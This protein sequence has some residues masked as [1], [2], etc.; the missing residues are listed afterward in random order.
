MLFYNQSEKSENEHL[1]FILEAA[2]IG[3]WDLD[4]INGQVVWDERCRQ[5]F[6]FTAGENVTY[7]EVLR[8]MHPDDAKIVDV[9]VKRALNPAIDE[10]YE[11][12][13]RVVGNDGAVRWILSK[14]KAYF[15]N[16]IAV[17]FAG[18][19]QDITEAMSDRENAVISARIAE[20]ALRG[21]N[22]GYFRVLLDTDEMEYSPDCARILT[23]NESTLPTHDALKK[24]IHPEDRPIRTAA[25]ELSRRTGKLDYEARVIWEDGSVHWMRAT[26]TYFRGEKGQ[27]D[28][29]AGTVHDTSSAVERELALAESE[30]RFR[31]LIEEAPVATCLFVGKEMR[32]E[33][34]NEIMLGYWGK[35]RSVMGKPFAVGVP[36]MIGQPFLDILDKVYTT[37]I[38][39]TDSGARADLEVDGVLGTY[40]FDFTYK[41]LRNADGEVY[42][43]MDMAVDVTQQV[44]ARQKIEEAEA[45]LRGAIELAELGTWQLDLHTFRMEFSDRMKEWFGYSDDE[46]ITVEKTLLVIRGDEKGLV[47]EKLRLARETGSYD[48]E[49][50]IIVGGKERILHAQG[51]TFYDAHQQPYKI[52]GTAQDVTAQRMLQLSLEEEVQ[53]R[54]EELLAVNEELS[55][56]NEELNESNK[57]LVH[58]NEELA[59]YAYVA[60]HDLQEPLRKIRMFSGI[61]ENQKE[62]PVENRPI[63]A[64]IAQSAERMSLLIRDLLDFSRL[65]K[66]E[67]HL[68]PVDLSSVLNAVISDFELMIEEKQANVRIGRLPV[69]WGVALQ[70]NQLFYNLLSNA[71]K[72]TRP[73]VSPEIVIDAEIIDRDS[74]QQYV[75]SVILPGGNYYHISLSDNGIGFEKKYAEQI[76]EVFKRLHGRSIYPG[77]GIGLALC[78]RIVANHNG[79]IHVESE[80]N[81]GTVFHLILPD[82]SHIRDLYE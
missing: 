15:E 11:V 49:Y 79:H 51:K 69:I 58:S 47:A 13:Y 82:L 4:P 33:V 23:G 80:V 55:T 27:S 14:G 78:R 59:Q 67:T 3:I 56:T 34:A 76:F 71:L 45:A 60:S 37:G 28:Y 61:L 35:D 17:R 65:L 6:G 73:D 7:S 38:T 44:H 2:G 42:A 70:M 29:I 68:R 64:K 30:E 50:R 20:V 31:S 26:G 19:A 25:Y 12:R 21:S 41:P 16:G 54:T 39:Y 74:A 46:V 18:T 53:L 81:R 63:V 77:S 9:A 10:A 62:L 1:R 48:M 57:Q 24:H 8:Y 75:S 40:Y 66:T 43:V 5:L 52:V 72:F 22:S 32:V 36:E